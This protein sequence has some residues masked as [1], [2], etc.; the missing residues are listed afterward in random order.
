MCMTVTREFDLNVV[1]I[2]EHW[3]VPHAIREFIANAL[4]EVALIDSDDPQ[5]FQDENKN[6]HIRD[7]GRGVRYHHFTQNEN[8]E[9]I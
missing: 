6:W 7:F 8:R 3:T 5:I 4:D 9:N 1:K 2:L